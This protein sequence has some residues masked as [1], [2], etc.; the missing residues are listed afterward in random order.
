VTVS[1]TT[2]KATWKSG[3]KFS[4]WAATLSAANNT[5]TID[6]KVCTISATVNT[7]A[8]SVAINYNAAGP[9]NPRLAPTQVGYTYNVQTPGVLAKKR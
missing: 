8:T 6:G 3:E 5:I 2:S 9:C 4:G 7:T 1:A